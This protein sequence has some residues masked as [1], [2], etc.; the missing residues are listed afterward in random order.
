MNGESKLCKPTFNCCAVEKSRLVGSLGLLL[1]KRWFL[2]NNDLFKN[3]QSS[4]F[5]LSLPRRHSFL[6]ML[7]FKLS[8]H[9]D[10]RF[11]QHSIKTIFP[12]SWQ[13]RAGYSWWMV[14]MIYIQHRKSLE[15]NH[16]AQRCAR[17][18]AYAKWKLSIK[19]PTFFLHCQAQN[20][21]YGWCSIVTQKKFWNIADVKGQKIMHAKGWLFRYFPAWLP[22]NKN[23]SFGSDAC[24]SLYCLL[25]PKEQR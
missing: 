24:R 13:I 10:H 17:R 12:Q 16:I 22:V 11:S 23:R 14:L 4:T 5:D 6:S 8:F 9:I 21:N 25:C 1:C 2:R 19:N 15:K 20:I 18:G 3:F 7:P